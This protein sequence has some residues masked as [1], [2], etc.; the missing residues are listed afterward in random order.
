VKLIVG[1]RILLAL[2][3]SLLIVNFA[4]AQ[5]CATSHEVTQNAACLLPS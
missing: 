5:G 2:A 4:H 1:I 3:A